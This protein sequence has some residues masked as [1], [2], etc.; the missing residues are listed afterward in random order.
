MAELDGLL[1]ALQGTPQLRRGNTALAQLTQVRPLQAASRLSNAGALAPRDCR[2]DQLASLATSAVAVLWPC[3]AIRC[4]C[5]SH[6]CLAAGLVQA[7]AG[8]IAQTV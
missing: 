2:P 1:A 5:S 7:H 3:S 8:W 4:S 6:A